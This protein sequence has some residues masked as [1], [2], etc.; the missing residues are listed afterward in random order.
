MERFAAGR[1]FTLTDAR[2]AGLRKDQVYALLASGAVDRVGRG[3]FVERGVIDP[4]WES[5]TAATAVRPEAT[6][7]LTSALLHYDLTDM[8]PFGTDIALPRGKRHPAGF[9]HVAW[10]SFDTETFDV[11][12]ERVKVA[13]DVEVTIYSAER[14]I[15]DVFRLMHREGS[16]VAYEAL[17]RWIRKRGSSP[18]RLMAVAASFPRT[19]SR[20]QAA[21]QVLL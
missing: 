1:A 15:V 20:L 5:L 6:L 18:A 8:I 4:L 12:R 21:L 3:V 9:E 16:D 2:A 7:C 14:T 19:E 13:P 17:R 10:H 11:G